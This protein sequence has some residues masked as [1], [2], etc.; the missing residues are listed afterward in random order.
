VAVASVPRVLPLWISLL[1][2]AVGGIAVGAAL[3]LLE[4][5]GVPGTSDFGNYF[6]LWIVLVTL[7]AARSHS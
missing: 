6:G 5:S 4:I 2:A 3:N 1:S 7:I